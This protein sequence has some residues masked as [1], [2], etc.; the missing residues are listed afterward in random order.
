MGALVGHGDKI[1][2]PWPGHGVE[3]ALTFHAAK[4]KSLA[5]D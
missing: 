2:Q 3:K 4:R 1:I 5:P